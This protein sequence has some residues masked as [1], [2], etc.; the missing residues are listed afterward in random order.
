VLGCGW[1]LEV[2]PDA[3]SR[4][5][6]FPGKAAEVVLVRRGVLDVEVGGHPETLQEGD[7]LL[8]TEAVIGAWRNPG[9]AP[10]QLLWHVLR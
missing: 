6:L 3:G 9:A 4:Q 5:P 10:A 8:A 2:E 1:E 7:T